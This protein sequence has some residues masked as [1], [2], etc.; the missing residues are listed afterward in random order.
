MNSLRLFWILNEVVVIFNYDLLGYGIMALS[1]FFT[2]LSIKADRTSDKWLK[3][4]M[5][6]HGIFFISCFFMPMTGVF[7]NTSIGES[8][9]GGVIA[10]VFWCV[11][12]LPIGVLSYFHFGEAK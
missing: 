7:S 5:I 9:S 2:G 6:I 12:F 8:S 3:C 11:Y 4:L 1:T 10:L